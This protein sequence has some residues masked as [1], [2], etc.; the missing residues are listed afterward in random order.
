MT[1]EVKFV[2]DLFFALPTFPV[3]F[4]FASSSLSEG[5]ER[6][7]LQKDEAEPPWKA[8]HPHSPYSL[9]APLTK[10]CSR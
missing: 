3:P 4:T 8:S 7:R 2:N 10:L 6:A 1:E 5:Q 9:A